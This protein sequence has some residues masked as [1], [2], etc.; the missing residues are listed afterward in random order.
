MDEFTECKQRN[1]SGCFL[2]NPSLV[3][4]REYYGKYSSAFQGDKEPKYRQF[5][6]D[7]PHEF[8][9]YILDSDF[10]TQLPVRLMPLKVR[11]LEFHVTQIE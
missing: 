3:P 5:N 10:F 11:L 4:R 1:C 7:Q 2:D 9:E 8:A 6:F